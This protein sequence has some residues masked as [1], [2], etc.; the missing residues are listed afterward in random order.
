MFP[1]FLIFGLMVVGNP[2]LI[3][4]LRSLV[5]VPLFTLLQSFLT[6]V[7]GVHAH[8]LDAPHEGSSH[9]F[10][11]I[12]GPIQSVQRAEYWGVI[13]ALQAYSGIHIGIDNLN[14]LRGVAALSLIRFPGPPFRLRRMVIC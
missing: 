9:I 3:L 5:L 6:V 11:G 8:D 2:S 12:P 10:S 1:I 13:L 14:V 7:I 4:I